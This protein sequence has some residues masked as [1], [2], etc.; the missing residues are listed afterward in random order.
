MRRSRRTK[1]SKTD[2]PRRSSIKVKRPLPM[3]KWLK[4]N[5]DKH[6]LRISDIVKLKKG[7]KLDVLVVDRNFYDIILE[8]ASGRPKR[9]TTLL[10]PQRGTYTH[11]KNLEGILTI[12]YPEETGGDISV[13]NGQFEFEV[14]VKEAKMWYPLIRGRLD[15]TLSQGKVRPRWVPWSN[16]P[17]NT[18]VGYRGYMIPWAVVRRAPPL[19]AE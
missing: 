17:K 3:D 18:H 14:L 6:G 4:A 19:I 5:K 9:A 10:A 11:H 8:G 2:K 15:K 16:L 7:D 13:D 12:H 1:S